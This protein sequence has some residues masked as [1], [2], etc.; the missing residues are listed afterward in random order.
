MASLRPTP[1]KRTRRRGSRD[2][3]KA[4]L[5]T[6]AEKN[7]PLLIAADEA[8]ARELADEGIFEGHSQRDWCFDHPLLSQG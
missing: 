8:K 2:V 3:K 5:K 7:T 6:G 4:Y 1:I